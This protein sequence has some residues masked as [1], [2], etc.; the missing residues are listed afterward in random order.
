MNSIYSALFAAHA[1]AVK[2]HQD[3]GLDSIFAPIASE[4]YMNPNDLI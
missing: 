3:A 2:L 4:K 1:S